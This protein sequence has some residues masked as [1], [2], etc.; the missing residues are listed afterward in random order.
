MS[1][2]APRTCR[3]IETSAG[4]FRRAFS[5][6]QGAPRTCRCIE[7]PTTP[8]ETPAFGQ[9]APRTCRCIETVAPHHQI[10]RNERQ[11]APRTCRCIETPGHTGR[12]WC[13]R[14][15]REHHAPVGA[16]RRPAGGG[17]V[18]IYIVRE[19]HAPVGALRQPSPLPLSPRVGRQGAPRTCRC[20]ETFSSADMLLRASC[21]GAPRT[22]RCIETV[23][24][25][26]P[27]RRESP[28]QGAPRTCRRIETD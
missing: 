3:C 27:Q 18:D 24:W 22:C 28:C 15:V 1:Q 17:A 20:I 16:L 26:E 19:H 6:C 23:Q 12:C 21:Q 5:P 10:R 4:Y 11:G 7:T 25:R 8:A 9:G 13:L 14:T 2:G